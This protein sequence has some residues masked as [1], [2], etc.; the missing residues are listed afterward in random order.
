MYLITKQLL[1]LILKRL[2]LAKSNQ[3]M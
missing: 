3:I 1:K 2:R